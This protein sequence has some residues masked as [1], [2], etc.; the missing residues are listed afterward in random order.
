MLPPEARLGRVAKLIEEASY[1]VV[2]APRQCGKTTSFQAL[3]E[4]LTREGRYTAVWATC[5]SAQ[6]A[7]DDAEKAVAVVVEAI[8]WSARFLPEAQ[9]PPSPEELQPSEGLHLLEVFL[10]SWAELSPLPIVLFFDEIDAL[11]G[12]SLISVLRQLR[13]GY[14]SRPRV[15]P[16]S[17]ALIGLRDVRD[18]RIEEGP[19]SPRLGTSSPFNIKVES[20]TLRNFTAEEVASLCLQ[21][22]EASGQIF[23]S[24]ALERVFEL[25]Q[26]QPWLVNALARQL[27]EVEVPN[28]QE[29]IDL[30]AVERAKERL[31][32]RRDTHLDSL[33]ARLR[34]PRLRRVIE[35]ILGGTI[36]SAEVTSDDLEYAIDLGLLRRTEGNIE[37]A[38]PIYR[39][40]IPRALAE[41]LEASL[42]L[43]RPTF[44]DAGG[45]LR[46][47]KLLAGFKDFWRENAESFLARSPYSEAAAQLVFMAFLHKVVNGGGYIDREYAVGSG[48]IDLCLRW[49]HKAGLERFAFELKVRRGSADVRSKG[50]DQLAGYLERLGLVEGTLVIFDS[51]PD[52]PPIAERG[53]EEV[54]EHRGRQ[55]RVVTL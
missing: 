11:R 9:R 48:R 35:P 51:R 46:I 23:E 34:E 49:P 14:T 50:L 19:Q 3:A 2:H 22:Q 8:R 4:R 20:L 32:L 36:F 42:T 1:F 10:A 47:D 27:V 41:V 12:N 7:G 26:G 30:E 52:A 21:H 40:V 31:V 15:F 13:A 43:S 24:A 18:Y 55:I 29:P 54:L 6:A 17:V 28:R 16:H 25:T 37:V 5:E 53:S 39:E 44:L 45:S 33:A 38:N